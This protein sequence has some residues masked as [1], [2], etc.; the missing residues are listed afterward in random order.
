MLKQ[1]NQR[2]ELSYENKKV[3]HEN[4]DIMDKITRL[5]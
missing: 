2:K 5:K 4:V 1:Y 3:S